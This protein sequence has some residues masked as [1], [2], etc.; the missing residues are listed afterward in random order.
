MGE[1]LFVLAINT[2]HWQQHQ[3]VHVQEYIHE[4]RSRGNWQSCFFD[5]CCTDFDL[6]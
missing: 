2:W 4:V 5:R 1:L 3:R 6:S